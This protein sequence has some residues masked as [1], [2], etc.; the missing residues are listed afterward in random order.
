MELTVLVLPQT[1]KLQGLVETTLGWDFQNDAAGGIYGED[2]EVHEMTTQL[3][4]TM[5]FLHQF[6][7]G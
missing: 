2:D 6:R 1:R 7:N 5:V 4:S 3:K